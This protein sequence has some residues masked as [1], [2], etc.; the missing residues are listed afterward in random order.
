M[1]ATLIVDAEPKSPLIVAAMYFFP[2][3]LV[4]LFW[5]LQDSNHWAGGFVPLQYR[6]LDGLWQATGPFAWVLMNALSIAS[7][8]ITF[9]VVWL[10]WLVLILTSRF[11][12]LPYAL[13]FL[14]SFLWC[15]SGFPPAALAIT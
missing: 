14:G 15:L 2:L 3:G 5:G 7:I 13:H 10:S 11:R 6:L 9:V 1:R 8:L 4:L 12:N